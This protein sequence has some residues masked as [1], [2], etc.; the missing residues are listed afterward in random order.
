MHN[1]MR[2][3]H[4]FKNNF[5]SKNSNYQQIIILF[6]SCSPAS[7]HYRLRMAPTQQQ[8]TAPNSQPGFQHQ[9]SFLL[10]YPPLSYTTHR[11]FTTCT[12]ISPQHHTL[13]DISLV[14]STHPSPAASHIAYTIQPTDTSRLTHP[15]SYHSHIWNTLL[16]TSCTHLHTSPTQQN[17]N[18]TISPPST[19]TPTSKSNHTNCNAMDNQTQID[20]PNHALHSP[21]Q[22]TG[23]I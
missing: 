6:L 11:S 10:T 2:G 12:T 13:H 19:N 22:T 9:N 5:E 3:F 21:M 23:L 15:P 18:H 17:G 20:N 16:L 7:N 4:L 14:R 1:S 8:T